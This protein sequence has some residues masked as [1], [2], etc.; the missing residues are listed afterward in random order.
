MPAVYKIDK[1]RKLVLSTGS[2][3]V[4]KE[5]VFSHQDQILKD[6]DFDPSFSELADFAQLTD[7]DIGIGDLRTI[8]QRDVFSIHS[9]R[10]FI[11]NGDVAFGFAKIFEVYRQLAGAG[12]IRVFRTLD[13]AWDWILTPG[14]VSALR[15][16]EMGA[17]TSWGPPE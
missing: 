15:P 11:V 13:E 6:P 7:T 17:G 10:A 8:A 5:E 9:R 3:F 12:G 4:T 14:A 1:E 2:G 16:P